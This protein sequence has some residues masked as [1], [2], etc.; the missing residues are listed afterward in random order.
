MKD[1]EKFVAAMIEVRQRRKLLKEAV[2]AFD[3]EML[4][5]GATEVDMSAKQTHAFHDYEAFLQS[6]IMK[7]GI[8][9]TATSVQGSSSGAPGESGNKE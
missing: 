5:R 9:P 2:D 8:K 3:S 6:P 4:Q 7:H 1:A